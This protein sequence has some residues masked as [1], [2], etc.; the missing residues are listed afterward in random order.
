MRR[1]RLFPLFFC[2]NRKPY[3][4][5]SEV[6]KARGRQSETR[7]RRSEEKAERGT[8]RRVAKGGREGRRK[9]GE[10]TASRAVKRMERKN[11]RKRRR[12]GTKE[13][14][15]R[16]NEGEEGAGT[17]KKQVPVSAFPAETGTCPLFQMMFFIVCR[18]LMPQREEQRQRSCS[19][20]PS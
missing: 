8:G 10:G 17:D 5:W 14:T 18:R 7:P 6:P 13:R 12:E 1:I 11:G 16:R 3:T 9:D 2:L 15:E 20:G 19:R 4:R